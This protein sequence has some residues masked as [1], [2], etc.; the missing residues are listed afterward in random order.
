MPVAFHGGADDGNVPPREVDARPCCATD[1]AAL[2]VQESI[3]VIDKDNRVR[4]INASAARLLGAPSDC[5]GMSIATASS[6]IPVAPRGFAVSNASAVSSKLDR[7]NT[8]PRVL[9]CVCVR[10]IPP[11]WGVCSVRTHRTRCVV[12]CCMRCAPRAV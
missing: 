4:L 10:C 12:C 11:C 3:V 7:Y 8:H 6:G 5:H 1:L 9:S 2:H